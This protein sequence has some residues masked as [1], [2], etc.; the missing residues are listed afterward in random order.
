MVHLQP[1]DHQPHTR[2][3]SV[4]P[5]SELNNLTGKSQGAPHPLNFAPSPNQRGGNNIR[6]ES[7]DHSQHQ[8]NYG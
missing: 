1:L 2:N 5:M 6:L 4:P 8:I 3:S 7:I